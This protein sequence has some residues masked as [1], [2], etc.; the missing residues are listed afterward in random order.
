MFAVSLN[1]QGINKLAVMYQTKP[2]MFSV[3]LTLSIQINAQES[4]STIFSKFWASAEENIYPPALIE[5]HFTNSEYQR[6]HQLAKK[7][8]C[9]YQLTPQIN[10]FL[11][12]LNVSHTQF[13]DD[14]SI[15][16]Y[17]FRSMFSTKKIN[18]PTVNHIGAQFRLL[19]GHYVIREVIH[20]YPADQAGLR[21]GDRILSANGVNF[22]PYHSFNRDGEQ[23]RLSVQRNDKLMHF[24]I[25]AVNE[26]PNLSFS[27]AITN[28]VKVYNSN[29][30]KIGYLR[31]W[32]GTHQGN[33]KLFRS[34]VQDKLGGTD[35][36]IVDL[37]GGFGGAWYDYLDVFYA[38]RSSYFSY[39]VLN[40]KGV[41]QHKAR[42]QTNPWH[43]TGPMVVLINEGTRS[44]KE[45][46]AYQFKKTDRATLVGTTTQGALNAGKGIFNNID[47]PYFLLLSTAEYQLDGNKIEGVGINA[48]IQV[49]YNLDKSLPRDPQLDTAIDTAVQQLTQITSPN[50]HEKSAEK[51]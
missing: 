41:S 33:S 35:A 15:D 25:D 5:T 50:T 18:E 23:V 14:N 32:S 19:D 1:D 28:S 8:T 10:Q 39:A 4:A 44:G 43:Y 31:L 40:R 34:L 6:L 45:A 24:D 3:L 36:I 42:P 20:G 37:R 17:L 27:N 11:R 47:Q 30:F 21:R 26:N 22:H 46:L 48:D 49:D 9:V 16:F 2:L 12:S 13:Y 29:K 38:D 7:T 51:N